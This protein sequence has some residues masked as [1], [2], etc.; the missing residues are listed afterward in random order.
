MDQ[1][2]HALS[3]GKL[4]VNFQT[5]EL[6]LRGYLK[7]L[8]GPTPALED[9][10]S[11]EVGDM[12]PLNAV[13]NF[14]SLGDLVRKF[15]ASRPD[16]QPKIDAEVVELRDALVHGRISSAGHLEQLRLIKYSKPLRGA[17]QVAVVYKAP[18]TEEWFVNNIALVVAAMAVVWDALPPSAMK[19]QGRRLPA[20]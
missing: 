2:Q 15:N 20:T 14:D 10:Y 18:V 6:L 9:M 19:T 12:V 1:Q 13:T 7:N 11:R 8:A 3:L 4:L 17:N 5:L 16:V